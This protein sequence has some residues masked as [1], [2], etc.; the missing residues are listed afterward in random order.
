MKNTSEFGKKNCTDPEMTE[1]STLYIIVYKSKESYEVLCDYLLYYI[2][3]LAVY[4]VLCDYLL[5]LRF[6]I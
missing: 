3:I 5:L 4:V 1:S 2:A 6:S